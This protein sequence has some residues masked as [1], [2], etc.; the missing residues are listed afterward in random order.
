MTRL[1][2]RRVNVDE[3]SIFFGL[4][5]RDSMACCLGLAR[6]DTDL[7]TDQFVYE[8]GLAN[9]RSSNDRNVAAPEISCSGSCGHADLL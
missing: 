4:Y 8:R 1:K 2:T 9:V 6:R 7:G 5:A 3:L